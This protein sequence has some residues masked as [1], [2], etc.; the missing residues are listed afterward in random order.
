MDDDVSMNV[1][2]T[3]SGNPVRPFTRERS[4]LP[5]QHGR[6]ATEVLQLV[7]QQISLDQFDCLVKII[8]PC[9]GMF[10]QVCTEHPLGNCIAQI[11]ILNVENLTSTYV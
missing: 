10:F 6:M 7:L 3:I 5:W 11:I 2:Q 8:V 1:K 9:N 4:D